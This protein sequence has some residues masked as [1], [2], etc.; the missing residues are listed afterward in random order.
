M[1]VFNM[2]NSRM[3]ECTGAYKVL[4]FNGIH[5]SRLYNDDVIEAR[6]WSWTLMCPL[7]QEIVSLKMIRKLC[8]YF[9]L[10]FFALTAE[11]HAS[12]NVTLTS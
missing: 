12:H 4:Y 7:M 5:E 3:Y 6:S 1:I 8:L 2:C 11:T 10:Y 9:I